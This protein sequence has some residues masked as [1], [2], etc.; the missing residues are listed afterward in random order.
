MEV[1]GIGDR[2]MAGEEI[3]GVNFGL[4]D[5]VEILEGPG[6]G[7]GGAIIFLVAL[8]PEPHYL[9]ALGSGSGDV[10]VR[11]SALRRAG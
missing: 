9:V 7:E 11:Q 5:R 2:W 4:N 6:A 3:P 8:R 10:R 1:R